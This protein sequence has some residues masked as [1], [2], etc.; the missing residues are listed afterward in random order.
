MHIK[1]SVDWF[2]GVAVER[3]L[4]WWHKAALCL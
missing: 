3:N 2:L 1:V 4:E